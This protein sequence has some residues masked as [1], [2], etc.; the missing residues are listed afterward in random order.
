MVHTVNRSSEGKNFPRM[1]DFGK[2]GG[3]TDDTGELFILEAGLELGLGLE[4]WGRGETQLGREQS[5]GNR[6][7]KKYRRS[8]EYVSVF[9]GEARRAGV[10][11]GQG[12]WRDGSQSRPLY[13]GKHY[14]Y[15]AWS[16]AR[17]Q[18]CSPVVYILCLKPQVCVVSLN[19]QVSVGIGGRR[20]RPGP[21]FVLRPCTW[22][23]TVSRS[24]PGWRKAAPG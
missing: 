14:K 18:D 2:K 24:A 4:E 11:N 15:I 9:V 12:V 8:S 7:A 20:A 22:Y 3:V 17:K 1:E 16:P 21:S 19:G 10:K 6:K 23:L 13:V 5:L